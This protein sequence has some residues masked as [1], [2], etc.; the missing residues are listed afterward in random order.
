MAC[1][2][3]NTQYCTRWDMLHASVSVMQL[4]LCQTPRS[5]VLMSSLNDTVAWLQMIKY[6]TMW[7]NSEAL[8]EAGAN[9]VSNA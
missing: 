4:K 1:A 9:K 6:G 8:P 2:L 7:G 5:G 3:L